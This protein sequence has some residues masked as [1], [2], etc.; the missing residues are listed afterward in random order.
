MEDAKPLETTSGDRRASLRSNRNENSVHLHPTNNVS[1]SEDQTPARNNTVVVQRVT[2]IEAHETSFN[3]TDGDA[4][5][6]TNAHCPQIEQPHDIERLKEAGH[7]P[8]NSAMLQPRPTIN[9]Q[10]ATAQR[11]LVNLLKV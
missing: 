6:T 8:S 7:A 5:D 9:K 3:S 1:E 4:Q 2:Q 11:S 10:I